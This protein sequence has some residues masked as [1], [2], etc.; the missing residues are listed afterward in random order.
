MLRTSIIVGAITVITF[1]LFSTRRRDKFMLST[2][3]GLSAG[4][5]RT[6]RRRDSPKEA[7]HIGLINLRHET[8]TPVPSPGDGNCLF[9]SIGVSVGE[10]CDKVRRRVVTELWRERSK[11]E[12]FFTSS[13][14][15]K[16]YPRDRHDLMD[17]TYPKYVERMLQPGQWGGELELSAASSVYERPIEVLDRNFDTIST[18]GEGDGEPIRVLYNGSSHYDGVKI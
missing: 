17:K 15:N 5:I 10:T 9:S 12:P 16:M 13:M 7:P 11:Y 3:V 14:M 8:Y 4:A 1:L 2:P 6:E 18:Y